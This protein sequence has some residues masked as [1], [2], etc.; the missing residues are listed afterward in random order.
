MAPLTLASAPAP[1][2]AAEDPAVFAVR[3]QDVAVAVGKRT[4]RLLRYEVKGQARIVGAVDPTPALVRACT[5]NDRAGFPVSAT[6]VTPKWLCDLL[7]P[8]AP[9]AM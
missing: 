5:D 4:G 8:Y 7:E 3:G 9:W 2:A 1:A 6:F